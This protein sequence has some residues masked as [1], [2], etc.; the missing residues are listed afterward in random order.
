MITCGLL[1]YPAF[2]CVIRITWIKVWTTVKLPVEWW[3]K[4]HYKWW[5]IKLR[6]SVLL[7]RSG[8]TTNLDGIQKILE[9]LSLSEFHP[10]G[11]GSQ[12]LCCTTSQYKNKLKTW[13]NIFIDGCCN[14]DKKS[15]HSDKLLKFPVLFFL[16][17]LRV[18]IR[19]IRGLHWV[20]PQG[21]FSD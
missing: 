12:T 1:F 14:Y 9:A 7:F 8:M 4:C 20:K 13:L 6:C 10:T 18:L 16:L 5:L 11:Y 15:L 17:F 19:D 3:K 2:M 21:I